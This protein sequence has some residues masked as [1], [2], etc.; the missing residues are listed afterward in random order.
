MADERYTL[1]PVYGTT[2]QERALL[3]PSIYKRF[4]DLDQCGKVCVEYVWIGGTGE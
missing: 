1:T 4:D 3:D 2:E